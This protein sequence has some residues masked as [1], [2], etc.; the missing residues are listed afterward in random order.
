MMKRFALA[1]VLLAS[2]LP[3]L[4]HAA[5]RGEA[6]ATVAGK[7][8]AIEYGRPMLKGRDMLAQAEVGKPWRMGADAATT[9]KT[10]ADLKFGTL[11]VPKG[12]Y[13]LSATKVAEG[14]WHLNLQNAADKASVGSVPLTAH[15]MGDNVET[16]TIELA[17][18]GNDGELQLKWGT[19]ALKTT[20]SGK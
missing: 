9:L 12:D 17:G 6:K 7:S 2:A 5:D 8:V 10:D 13:V 16:F 11:A 3:A 20:F 19:T 14:Q 15:K 18:K 1:A 4:A